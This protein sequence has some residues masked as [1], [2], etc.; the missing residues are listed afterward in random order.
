MTVKYGWRLMP[1][2]NSPINILD[3]KVVHGG[4]PSSARA[5]LPLVRQRLR[6]SFRSTYLALPEITSR[7]S[8]PPKMFGKEGRGK[9]SSPGMFSRKEIEFEGISGTSLVV[10]RPD[11]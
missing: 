3:L 7:T 1:M 2:A 4:L 5:M 6:G 11:L 10:N 9:I 8:G